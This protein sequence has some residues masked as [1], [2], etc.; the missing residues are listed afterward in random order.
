MLTAAPCTSSWRASKVKPHPVCNA[1]QCV[2]S[3]EEYSGSSQ[4]PVASK[5]VEIKE[6][7]LQFGGS[8]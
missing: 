8:L 7:P 2:I 3:R 1:R 6:S 4:S 5:A